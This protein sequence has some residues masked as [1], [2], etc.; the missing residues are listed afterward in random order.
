MVDLKS[1]DLPDVSD[2]KHQHAAPLQ[3]NNLLYMFSF[4]KSCLNLPANLSNN[5][6]MPWLFL[7]AVIRPLSMSFSFDASGKVFLAAYLAFFS[8][9]IHFLLLVVAAH[10]LSLL[11]HTHTHIWHIST[12]TFH[13]MLLQWLV[14]VGCDLW[15]WNMMWWCETQV[16]GTAKCWNT[17]RLLMWHPHYL[18]RELH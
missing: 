11:T 4:L 13:A 17:F 14:M 18:Y 6:P 15:R 8:W 7:V 3:E 5:C 1:Y 16:N 2:L 10:L 9:A 12:H